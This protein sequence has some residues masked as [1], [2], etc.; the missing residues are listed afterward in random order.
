MNRLLCTPAAALDA[1][2]Q[3]GGYRALTELQAGTRT[4]ASVQADVASSGL[5]GRGGAWFP[6]DRKWQAAL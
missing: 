1:Y 2:R 4:A 6:L 3:A 5:R